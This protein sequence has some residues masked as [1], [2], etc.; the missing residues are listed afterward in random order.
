MWRAGSWRVRGGRGRF[1][2]ILPFEHGVNLR[3][4]VI[5]KATARHPLARVVPGAKEHV[6]DRQPIV[7][8]VVAIGVVHAVHLGP[9]H[10]VA[11]PVR[12]VQISV[13]VQVKQ[14]R[15][16]QRPGRGHAGGAQDHVAGKA[17]QQRGGGGVQRMRVKRRERL[18]ARGT[19]MQ[20][21][22][23]APQAIEA[24]RGAVPPV[25][26]EAGDEKAQRAHEHIGRASRQ[27]P[28]RALDDGLAE[29][30]ADADGDRHREAAQRGRHDQPAAV[31]VVARGGGDDLAREQGRQY[32]QQEGVGV[33]VHGGCS[34]AGRGSCSLSH[35]C[36]VGH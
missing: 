29:H 17:A 35:R 18:N 28:Q 5:I 32:Q 34:V 3:G 36:S 9:L 25:K 24:V 4:F 11:H 23:A 26:D 13:Q 8:R 6:P 31:A 20:L 14:A 19:V 2:H 33:E 15:E 30:Q 1:V 12:R 27:G 21:V 10:D 22:H 16:Q 7:L